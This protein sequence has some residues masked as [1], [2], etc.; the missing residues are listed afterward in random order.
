VKLIDPHYGLPYGR[1][2]ATQTGPCGDHQG[3]DP[4]AGGVAED[5]TPT[6]RQHHQADGGGPTRVDTPSRRRLVA[7]P[8]RLTLKECR[9]LL[10]KGVQLDDV[11]LRR[12]RDTL[13]QIAEA[14]LE[15]RER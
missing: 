11:E 6:A 7:E 4:G 5:D 15:C 14:A 10:P 8:A 2:Y 9:D 13:Y 12:V 3:D 1:H